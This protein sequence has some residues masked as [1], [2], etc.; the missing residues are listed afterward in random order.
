M[1]LFQG[2]TFSDI[3]FDLVPLSTWM[4]S[5][6]RHVGLSC[7]LTPNARQAGINEGAECVINLNAREGIINDKGSWGIT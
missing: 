2:F 7:Y 6:R 3:D 5:L 4:G 1:I